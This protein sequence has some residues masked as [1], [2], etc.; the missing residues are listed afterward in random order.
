MKIMNKIMKATP[1]WM[2]GALLFLT[3][4]GLG[5]FVPHSSGSEIAVFVKE[6]PIYDGQKKLLGEFVEAFLER[7]A[8]GCGDLYA[9]NAIYMIPETP[10]LEGHTAILESYK[11]QFRAPPPSEMK[12]SEPVAEVL[13]MGDWAVVRGT[14]SST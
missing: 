14:G 12:M 10:V 3:G 9:E 5:V 13:A 6:G 7:D 4:I 11:E 8:S 2:I 1:I